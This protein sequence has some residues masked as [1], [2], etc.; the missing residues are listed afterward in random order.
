MN[1]KKILYGGLFVLVLPALL[2]LWSVALQDKVVMPLY[3][4]PALGWAFAACGL[5]TAFAGMSELWRFG[6]GLPMNAFP[7]PKLVTRGSYRYLPHPI[8]IGF[9]ALCLGASMVAKSASGLWLVTPCVVLGCVALVLGYERIDL[10]R[11]FGRTLPFLPA[12]EDSPPSTVERIRFL[13]LVVVPWLAL[14]ELTIQLP[15]HGLS[16]GFHF[17]ERLP[18]YPWTS[19]FY[20][21]VYLAVAAAP[22]LAPT[23]KD[24]RQLTI[25]AWVAMAVVFPIYWF[26]PSSAPRRLL[27]DNDWLTQILRFERTAYP[28]VAAFP[29]FHVIWALLVARLFRRRWIGLSYVITV[30]VSCVTTGMHYVAD[31]VA[32]LL[33]APVLLEP[34]RAWE[35]LRRVAE[36]LAN[37]WKEWRIGPLRLINH[38]LYAGVAALVQSA[39][40]L[41]AVGPGKEWKVMVTVV[42]GLVGAGAWAQWVEGSSILRRPFGFYGGLLGVGVSCLFFQERWVLLAAHCLG[43]PWMQAIGRM[44]CLVNGCCHGRPASASVG[45]RISHP[46]S[47]VAFMADLAGFPI[48]ATQL[49]SILGNTMLGLLLMRLWISG[50]PLALICGIYAIG[51][52]VSRFIEEGYRGE[53]QTPVVLG[54]RLYQWLA[55]ST[56]I[57]GATITTLHSP[58]PT[59]LRLY[60]IDLVLAATFACLAAVA[61][62]VDFPD[63]DRPLARLT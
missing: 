44:R 47:R 27:L 30:A 5:A 19:L 58:P 13:L 40:V 29:S 24:L 12:D 26:L 31:V 61:L 10:V 50:C 25:S 45:I 38:G 21:S 56:I 20:E 6:G 60:P 14:Y 33:V 48:H 16:F 7:P 34:Q 4:T 32:A 11:R 1:L 36:W 8:Y 55:V 37:S 2:I 49:Y 39:I 43:A 15:L 17:E 54:L 9:V 62:G 57:I 42:A 46:R 41:A 59:A 51:N 52:G 53:P 28:P 35:T 63:S 22:W 23:R 3:G 18:I